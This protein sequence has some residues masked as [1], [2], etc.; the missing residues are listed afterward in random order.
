MRDILF[1]VHAILTILSG[2]LAVYGYNDKI[3]GFYIFFFILTF[4]TNLAA[5]IYLKVIRQMEE[6]VGFHEIIRKK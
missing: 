5:M 4:F 2:C 3:N 1:F 6:R